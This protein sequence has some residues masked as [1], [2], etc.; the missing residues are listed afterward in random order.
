MTLPFDMWPP[1]SKQVILES[2]WN[3]VPNLTK[4]PQGVLEILHSQ[5]RMPKWPLTSALQNLI[6]PSL[7]PSGPLYQIWRIYL[8]VFPRYYVLK[9]GSDKHVTVTL[10]FDRQNLISSSFSHSEH[11]CKVWRKS[12]KTFFRY[13]IHKKS[14]RTDLRRALGIAI[15]QKSTKKLESIDV[16][17]TDAWG[18]IPHTGCW[19]RLNS[20]HSHR[21]WL[22]FVS[23]CSSQLAHGAWR[24][25]APCSFPSVS[26]WLRCVSLWKCE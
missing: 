9:H 15:S 11:L 8:K 18:H 1:K 26:I 25:G 7:S 4:F 6:R 17:V 20:G 19:H 5:N 12:L 22:V 2:E 24:S 13:H 16:W 14:R 21:W 10:T 3:F 23:P